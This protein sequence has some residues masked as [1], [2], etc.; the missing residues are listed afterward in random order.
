M[1]WKCWHFKNILNRFTAVHQHHVFIEHN[2]ST[3][4][5]SISIVLKAIL[6]EKAHFQLSVFSHC[7]T[8]N[9]NSEMLLTQLHKHSTSSPDCEDNCIKWSHIQ[10]LCL[11]R[12]M[13]DYLLPGVNPPSGESMLYMMNVNVC[14]L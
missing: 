11:L 6:I 3:A 10:R 12:Q 14:H 5:A 13:F 8:K 4:M 2:L 7:G 1:N 9:D